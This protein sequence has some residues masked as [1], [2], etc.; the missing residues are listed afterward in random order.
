MKKFLSV[1]LL[2]TLTASMLAACG[3]SNSDSKTADSTDQGGASKKKVI[4]WAWDPSFNGAA[5]KIAKELYQKEHPDFDLEVVD[6][7]KA[8]LEQKLNTNL[9][10]GVKEGLPDI[11]LVNDPN[12]QKYVASYPNTFADFTD[13]VDFTKFS[14]YKV[15][16]LRV[17]NKIY[18]VPFDIGVTGMFYR[19]DYLEQ[20]GY[21]AKDLENITWDQYIAIGKKVKEKT[22]KYMATINPNDEALTSILLQSAGSWY[23]TPENKGNFVNNPAMTETLRVYK[24][25]ADSGIAKPVTGWSEFVGSFNAGDVATVVSGVWQ[26]SSIMDAK[27]QSGKWKVAPIPKLNVQGGVN[28]SNEGGSSWF[29]LN[30]SANKDTAIDFLAKTIG[31]SSEFYERFLKENGGVGSYIPA[32]SSAAYSEKP[33]FFGGQAI[34]RD[35]TDWSKKVPGISLGMYT[36]EAKDALKNELPN[37]LQGADLTQSLTNIQSLFEQQVK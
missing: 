27:D 30:N 32:F 19:S 1:L 14:P 29:V 2:V 16:A 9:A 21:S 13:K 8:D 11:I 24:A 18:G 31:G 37:I 15:D 36:Q 10:A 17:D 7:A 34:Y 25:I 22:G 35:F 33:E 26:V 12:I 5:L 20:A 4:A 23:I 28:A 6:M 3:S